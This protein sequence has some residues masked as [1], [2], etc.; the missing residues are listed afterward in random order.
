MARPLGFA[1]IV[2]MPSGFTLFFVSSCRSLPCE[3][4]GIG[5]GGPAGV[6]ERSESP[7]ERV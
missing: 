2:L 7:A 6:G 1:R 5:A 3:A 4:F